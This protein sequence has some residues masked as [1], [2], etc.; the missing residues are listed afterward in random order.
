[1]R[2]P[3]RQL[4]SIAGDVA[5]RDITREE[6]RLG[7]FETPP[8]AEDFQQPGG[9]H[10]VAIFLPLAE[11]DADHH[12]LAVDMSRFQPDGLGDAQSGSVT[13]GQNG[14]VLGTR[15]A[16]EK[17]QDLLRAEHDGQFLGFLGCRDDLGQGP[18]LRRRR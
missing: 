8:V 18:I 5:A 2:F 1:M 7:L 11:F 13:S 9:E 3:A 6:P 4:D 17:V 12:A 10:D 16:T 15:Q 14:A